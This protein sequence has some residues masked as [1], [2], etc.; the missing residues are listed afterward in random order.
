MATTSQ[1]F[2]TST[3]LTITLAS[4][5]DSATVG[6]QSTVV[7]NTSDLY[8]D[9]LLQVSVT[10]AGT[11]ATPFAVYVYL[12]GSEDGTK[13]A[14]ADDGVIGA[15]DAAYTVNTASN[16]KGPFV[17]STPTTAKIYSQIVSVASFFGGRMPRKWGIVV[18]NDSGAA[19]NATGSNHYATY[20]GIKTSIA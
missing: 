7:D 9:A 16:L 4:L 15:T 11:V 20:T 8:E 14:G 5:A 6:R 2:G 19:L 18:V 1:L 13:Y 3:A 12:F 10:T 17:I